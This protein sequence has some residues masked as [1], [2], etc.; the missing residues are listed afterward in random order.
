MD[1]LACSISPYSPTLTV[2]YA[3]ATASYDSYLG[4]AGYT[5]IVLS[6]VLAHHRIVIDADLDGG[7]LSDAD[8]AAYYSY[9][10]RKMDF[11]IGLYRQSFRYLFRFS[12]G[13]LEEVRDNDLGGFGMASLP[14]SPS[15]R[16][17]GALG[18]RMLTRKGI[19]NSDADYSEEV[20]T[21]NA[22]AV[23]DN[24][25]WGSVGPRVGSRLALNLEVAPSV[26]GSASYGLLAADLR[27]YLWVSGAV[28]LA[29]RLAGAGSWGDD[30]PL[31]FLGGA[32]AHRLVW[33]EVDSLDELLGFY[34]NY[35]DL[36][37]GWDYAAMAGRK[38][39]L[40]SVELRVPFVR[41]LVLDAP[42]PLT[43]AD[44]RGA[45]F[46]DLG[47][48]FDDFTD[49][50]GA[51]T[52]GGYHLEDLRMGIGLG[53]RINL[54]ILLL[55]HDIA[56]RTTIRGISEKPVGYVTLGAEF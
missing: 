1:S 39:G 11:G 7:S 21:L 6:D 47:S 27:N 33:G 56:W 26:S 49:F 10:P 36:L 20:L 13:H 40:L 25:L 16:L 38:Y 34:S 46:V 4:L 44:G 35:G 43:L 3:S 9:L 12:D 50:R 55:R 32:M 30:A 19:W 31:F 45:F 53:Y 22:G 42:L 2:D 28:T 52:D 37:R 14:L 51:S 5:Q 18:Y 41:Q 8:V 23:L 54:G 24:A 15:F 17:E 48:A 29:T